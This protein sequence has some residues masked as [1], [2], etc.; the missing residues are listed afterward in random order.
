MA[1]PW[2]CHGVVAAHSLAAGQCRAAQ[3]SLFERQRPRHNFAHVRMS[4]TRRGGRADRDN[5]MLL[6]DLFASSRR[7]LEH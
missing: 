4:G 2:R 7:G 3:R 1:S 6:Q 5:R